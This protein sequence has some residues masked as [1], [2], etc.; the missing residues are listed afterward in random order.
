M[1]LVAS[2]FLHVAHGVLVLSLPRFP[3]PE[4][5]RQA[6]C[7]KELHGLDQRVP[8]VCIV[9]PL[10]AG[11]LALP[12]SSPHT[13]FV[14]SREAPGI[15]REEIMVLLCSSGSFS[16]YRLCASSKQVRKSVRDQGTM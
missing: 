16:L 13:R 12:G 4:A 8:H 1:C 5:L 10:D 14:P 7:E 6:V 2:T 3:P 9:F 11:V 15:P